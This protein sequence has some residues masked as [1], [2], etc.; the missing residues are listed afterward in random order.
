MSDEKKAFTVKDRRMFTLDGELRPDRPDEPEPSPPPAPATAPPA[1]PAG[2]AAAKAEPEP[3]AQ[4][5]FPGAAGPEGPFV[6]LVMLL[7][8]QV[9]A[10]MSAGLPEPEALSGLSQ[11][12]SVLEMLQH[13]T[14]GRLSPKEERVLDDVLYQLRMAYLARTQGKRA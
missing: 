10:M 8:D 13:R 2:A 12:V 7:A 1:E 9:N 14:R 5:S 3:P 6:L 11:I 4:E